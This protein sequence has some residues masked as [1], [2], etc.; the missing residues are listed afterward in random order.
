MALPP[1]LH[2]NDPRA[3]RLGRKP[4]QQT[5]KSFTAPRPGAPKTMEDEIHEENARKLSS[6]SEA[7]IKEAQVCR[8][9]VFVFIGKGKAT[10][11]YESSPGREATC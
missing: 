9:L 5:G 2:R 3:A 8:L 6:M 4:T 7:E 11:L 1:V 10:C